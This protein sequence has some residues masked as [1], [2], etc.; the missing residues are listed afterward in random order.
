M[1]SAIGRSG[2]TLPKSERDAA[3]QQDQDTREGFGGKSSKDNAPGEGNSQGRARQCGRGQGFI[4]Q[5]RFAS[6]NAVTC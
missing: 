6:Q 5:D 4:F 2:G 3:Q 1:E